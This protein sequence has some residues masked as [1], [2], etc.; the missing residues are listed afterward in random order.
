MGNFRV[1]IGIDVGTGARPVTLVALDEN[2]KGI[3]ISS[4]SP[5]DALAFAAGQPAGALAAVNAAA[6]PNRGRKAHPFVR[7]GQALV[8]SLEALGYTPFPA[9]DSPRQWL[10]AHAENAVR[11]L[12]GVAP[13]PAGTLEGRIQRQLVLLE[14][15]LDVPDAMD[16]FEEITRFRLLKSILPAE[17]IFPQA[18]LDAWIAAHTAWLADRR[19]EQVRRLGEEEGLVFLPCKPDPDPEK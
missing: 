13:L 4:G 10:A 18:E 6:R 8:E 16:F 12:L 3:A 7:R 14:E 19:P 17:N 5:A 9:D 1:Y 11:S 2:Q 15:G